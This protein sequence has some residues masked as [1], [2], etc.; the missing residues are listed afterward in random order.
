MKNDTRGFLAFWLT[1]SI[2]LYFFPF[3]FTGMVVVGNAR[4]APFLAG[5]IS[6]FL[7]TVADALTQPVFEKL[8]VKLKDEWQWALAYLFVNVLGV[9]V[10]AR[11]ADLTGVGV[12]S[13]W[14]A[15]LLGVILNL[16]QW[17]V[18]KFVLA[19]KGK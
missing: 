17:G 5:I 3:V 13:A 1:N 16:V 8:G 6:G 11:Y 2:L 18:W 4:L 12:A 14:V 10:L 9:W 19:G 7:L 15:V